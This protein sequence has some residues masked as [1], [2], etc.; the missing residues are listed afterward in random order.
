MTTVWNEIALAEKLTR[1]GTGTVSALYFGRRAL[2]ASGPR[3][4]AALVLTALFAGCALN[5]AALL[6]A[7]GGAV[8][9]QGA[10][11]LPLMA[12]NLAAFLLVLA[13]AG[14]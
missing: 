11:R 12:A 3:L 9:G 10:P 2:S 13:R 14:R 5:A 7:G 4:A 8:D 1:A 6:V